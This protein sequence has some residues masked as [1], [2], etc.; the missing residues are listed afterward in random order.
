VTKNSATNQG[1]GLYGTFKCSEVSGGAFEILSGTVSLKHESKTLR[2]V[3]NTIPY[4][5]TF[6]LA[7]INYGIERL[8]EKALVFR[9]KTHDIASDYVDRIYLNEGDELDFKVG[10]EIN[11]FGSR[12]SGR[13]ARTKIENL[14]GNGRSAISFDFAEVP[15]ISS[16]F[17]D[18]VFGKLFSSLGPIRFGQ[19][20]RFKN[21]D[22][23]CRALI[24][25]AI[26]QRMNT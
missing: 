9:G 10:S 17:A 26:M 5:G 8:L 3:R 13:H 22:G 6:V 19:L 2:V 12:E 20:C 14:M 25:R 7:S 15:L 4:N 21:I 11:A 16:S 23:T 18:E 1:N 24:D